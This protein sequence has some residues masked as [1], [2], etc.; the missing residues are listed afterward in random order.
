MYSKTSRKIFP[1]RNAPLGLLTHSSDPSYAR[2]PLAPQRLPSGISR[3]NSM[4]CPLTSIRCHAPLRYPSLPPNIC[5]TPRC[6]PPTVPHHHTLPG[7]LTMA[8][9]PLDAPGAPAFMSPWCHIYRGATLALCLMHPR[10]QV[11]SCVCP[12]AQ[13]HTMSRCYK[14][15]GTP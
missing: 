10:P 9:C 1:R 5:H 4:D 3:Y 13:S 12:M 7:A 2:S 14:G 6:L 11:A 8:L 15:A